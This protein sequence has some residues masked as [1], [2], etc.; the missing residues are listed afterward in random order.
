ME[1]P[2][3]NIKT[4]LLETETSGNENETFGFFLISDMMRSE[5]ETS[6]FISP[7]QSDHSPVVLM[8]RSA[9][10]AE[11]GRGYWKFNNSLPNDVT[12]LLKLFISQVIKKFKSFN[13]P[14]VNW[15]FFKYKLRQKAR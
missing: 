14:R 3:P 4:V 11:R 9:N 15:E 8:L 1:N 2:K 13:D 5:V 12:K 7:L 6:K 10:R